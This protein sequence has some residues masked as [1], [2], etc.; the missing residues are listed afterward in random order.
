M[1]KKRKENEWNLQI[2]QHILNQHG[3]NTKDK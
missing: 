2:D 1:K 3:S